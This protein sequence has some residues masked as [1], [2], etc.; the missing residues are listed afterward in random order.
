VPPPY[1]PPPSS[2]LVCWLKADAGVYHDAGV[3]LATNGQTVQQWN[4]Q[5]GSGNH[6]TQATSGD[7]PTY[8]TNVQNSLPGIAFNGSAT[9][10]FNGYTGWPYTALI[11]FKS[12]N[13]LNYQEFL[14]ADDSSH[15]TSNGVYYYQLNNSGMCH[16]AVQTTGG[17]TVTPNDTV[18]TNGTVYVATFQV[19]TST[20]KVSEVYQIN[21]T[22]QTSGSWSGS[23]EPIDASTNKPLI[24]AGW[25][26]RAVTDYL[27]GSIFEILIYNSIVSADIL[28]LAQSYLQ[29]KWFGSTSSTYI[30]SDFVSDGN[31]V[32]RTLSSSNATSFNTLAI[33]YTPPGS[34]IVR[35]PSIEFINGSYWVAHTVNTFSQKIT[36]FDIASSPDAVYWTSIGTVDC[37]SITGTTANARAWAPE[38]FQD[39]DGSVHILIALGS[40][41]DSNGSVSGFQLYEMHPTNQ[42]YTTWS[43][44]VQITGTSLPTNQI[45]PFCIKVS[46]TYYIW[47]KN[48]QT[49]YIEVMS[50]SSLTSGY[51]TLRTGQWQ[52]NTTTS[53]I[54]EGP[55]VIL[56]GSTWYFYCD[57]IT[58]TIGLTYAT[59]AQGAGDWTGTNAT[60]WSSRTALTIDGSTTTRPRH[61]TVLVAP[62]VLCPPYAPGRTQFKPIERR[63]LNGPEITRAYG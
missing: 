5:S 4:D 11:V 25:Y 27:N 51:T 42:G 46:G 52:G 59:Q 40:S 47:Y 34:D 57:S 14:G 53:D 6:A 50:S 36:Y 8:N 62:A 21:G 7:R 3:T 63:R 55:C 37:S 49:G 30:L 24:G 31:E 15:S 18:L 38:W 44:P 12:S 56:V 26:G 22:T 35:D 54:Y 32:L 60:A 39:T 33:S 28:V 58:D 20:T 19:N 41:G 16:L 2:G 48:Q 23:L 13:V 1:N 29:I 9:Y 17:Q 45:D 61:G 43:S 10:L